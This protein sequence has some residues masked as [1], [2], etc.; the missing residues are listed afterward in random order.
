MAMTI[1]EISDLLNEVNLKHHVKDDKIICYWSCSKY[2]DSDGDKSLGVII[3][4]D[5]NGEFL[6]TFVPN[7]YK[8]K[9]GPNLVFVLE[10]CMYAS[11]RTKMLQFEYDPSD[12]EIRACIEVPLEDGKLTAKQL[13]RILSGFPGIIDQYDDTIRTAIEQ[14]KFVPKESSDSGMSDLL[15][16]LRDL[17]PEGF[18]DLLEE[19]KKR[20]G[21]AGKTGSEVPTEL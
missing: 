20:R 21:Q 10:A 5:E 7:L 16:G 8:Y 4:L 9:D 6:E 14:G 2:K 19:I 12:G 17:G 1:Q 11:W 3:K 13:K 15:S 18:K